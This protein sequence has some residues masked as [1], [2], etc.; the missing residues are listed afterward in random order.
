MLQKNI[1]KEKRKERPLWN[2]YYIR[3]TPTKRE[4][5]DKLAKKHKK[6]LDKYAE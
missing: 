2:G 5:L 6:G 3:K 1:E 4:K